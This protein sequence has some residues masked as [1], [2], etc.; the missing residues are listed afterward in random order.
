MM[1]LF[2]DTYYEVER[3][4]EFVLRERGSKFYAYVYP[5][6]SEAEIKAKLEGLKRLYPDATHHCYAWVMGARG[7]AQRANDDGEPGNSAGRPI[8]RAVIS[9]GLTN[10]LVVVV[11]Y[12]GGTLLGIPGLI[13][14]YGGAAAAAL[15]AAGKVEKFIEEIYE[16][17]AAFEHE[18]EIHRLIAKYGARVLGSEYTEQVSYRVA[19]KASIGRSFEQAVADHYQLTGQLVVG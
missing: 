9:V 10:V 12:F 11:R 3:D 19:V 13:E 16:I 14:S 17:S 18:Q 15:A 7:E 6:R 4:A 5:V 8:L 1:G 2:S